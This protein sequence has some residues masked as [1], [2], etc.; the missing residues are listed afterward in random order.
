MRTVIDEPRVKAVR[1][2][3]LVSMT[4]EQRAAVQDKYEV[5]DSGYASALDMANACQSTIGCDGAI[6]V[7]WCGMWL[8]IETDGYTH[9]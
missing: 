4:D 8:C 7:Q 9:S 5:N 3:K 6:T 2:D 1:A